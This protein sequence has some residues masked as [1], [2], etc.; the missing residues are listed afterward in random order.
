MTRSDWRRDTAEL[1]RADPAGKGMRT[2]RSTVAIPNISPFATGLSDIIRGHAVMRRIGPG[3]PT[4]PEALFVSEIATVERV[5][6]FV[7]ARRRLRA[8]DAEEFASHVKIKLIENDYAVLRK[9]EGR[10]SL[11][12]YLTVVVQRL[13][14]DYCAATLGRWRPSAEA[15]RAGEVG[16][17]LEQLLRRDGYSFDEA[18]EILITNHQL[19]V[20]RADLERL[21]ALLP[22]RS[23]RQFE[24][25]QSLEDHPNSAPGAEELVDRTERSAIAGRVSAAL[26]QFIAGAEPQDRLILVLRFADQRKVP[27]IAA[28]LRIDQKRLYRR[29]D[30]LLHEMRIR[31]H[32]DGIEADEAL[33]LFDDPSI[34]IDWW[35]R[36]ADEGRR[37]LFVKK[38]RPA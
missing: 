13:L 37:D 33:A 3:Q 12:T 5:I 10:S 1:M 30:E 7:V 4:S 24:G 26:K 21:A 38:E 11:R 27:E 18:C 23:K 17:L 8:A 25:D 22:A 2:C 36:G 16:I 14:I 28:L 20:D 29:L 31:L 6:A 15:R 9:F 32:D 19:A 35:D 34:S